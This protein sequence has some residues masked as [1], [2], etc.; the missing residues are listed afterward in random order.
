M[1]V[2]QQ[3]ETSKGE[4]PHAGM[5]VSAPAVMLVTGCA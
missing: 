3:S 5:C 2:R 4:M 1:T